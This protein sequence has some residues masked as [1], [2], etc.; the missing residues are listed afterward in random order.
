MTRPTKFKAEIPD[1]LLDFKQPPS[2]SRRETV[3]AFKSGKYNTSE[4]E[5]QLN[6][7]RQAVTMKDA[8]KI[9]KIL[10]EMGIFNVMKA[11][12]NRYNERI[13]EE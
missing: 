10:P 4:E 5:R 8:N 9:D 12:T 11:N 6:K 7:L 3:A 1:Y 13:D 2:Y